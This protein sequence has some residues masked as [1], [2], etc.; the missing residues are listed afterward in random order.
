MAT[1]AIGVTPLNDHELAIAR[2]VDRIAIE[3]SLYRTSIPEV[4][5]AL[6]CMVHK[7]D[8]EFLVNYVRWRMDHPITK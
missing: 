5:A 3:D 6:D 1:A 2:T 7:S 4:A 8:S